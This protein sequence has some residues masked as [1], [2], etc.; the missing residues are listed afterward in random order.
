[1]LGVQM[2]KVLLMPHDDNWSCEFEKT[3][4]LIHELWG[5]NVIDVQHVGSTAIK[6]IH[7][8]PILDIAV[9]LKQL[10]LMD[11]QK[12]ENAGYRYMGSRTDNGDRHLYIKLIS[13]DGE[14]NI[15]LEHI[16]CY[17]SGA[18]D[19]INQIRFRDFLNTHPDA[20]AEYDIL[21][22]RMAEAN[23]NDRYAYSAGKKEFIEEILKRAEAI[24]KY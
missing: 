8:K 15:A 14:E 17:E 24:A 21:K 9:V 12:M 10:S 22:C 6:N 20:A 16:H 18:L 1:M 2:M 7:A 19:L 23:S 5:D 4:S 11:V 13:R 3:K